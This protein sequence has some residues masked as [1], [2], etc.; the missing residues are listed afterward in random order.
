MKGILDG[1][2]GDWAAERYLKGN[3]GEGEITNST[4]DALQDELT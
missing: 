4:W 3:G 2:A 1:N